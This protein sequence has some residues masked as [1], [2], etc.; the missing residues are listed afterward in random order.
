ML[1]ACRKNKV[2]FMDGVMFMHSQRLPLLRQILDDGKSV[3]RVQRIASQF[4]FRGADDFMS[5]NIR[6]NHELEPL[7]ALGDLG[8]YNI[9]FAL[10]TMNE[11][12]PEKV[13]ARSLSER[14]RDERGQ[15]VPVEFAGELYFAGSVSSSFYC[16]FITQNQQWAHV[17]G[18]L[19]SV[20]LSDFVL[21]FYGCESEF[22]V[23]Q[24]VFRVDG[25][26]FHMEKHVSRHAVA[27]YSDGKP[28]SQETNMIRKFADIVL[29]GK[30]EQ[31]WGEQA[32]KT[33][34][35]IDAC[36]KSARQSAVVDCQ[37]SV[38]MEGKTAV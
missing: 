21:P 11:Q 14:S 2:Q 25:C 27:E 32:F 20:H 12:L 9:R 5:S 37:V 38:E 4:S 15:P 1:E 24:P 30:L 26:D 7:G 36:V 22:E 8:W 10:W 6:V 23:S 16:S 18:P 33:Q 17:S 31:A 29:S 28:G 3:G 35:V 19:G 34:L 13:C